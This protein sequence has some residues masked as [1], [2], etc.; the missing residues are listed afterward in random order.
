M[1]LASGKRGRYRYYKCNTQ[2]GKGSHLFQSKSIAMQKLD[3]IVLEALADKVFT[4]ERVKVMLTELKRRQ[5]AT[6]GDKE[7]ELRPLQKESS[8]A[9]SRKA[10]GYMRQWARVT[11]R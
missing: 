9:S 5:Q 10:R 3:G 11:C 4:P 6:L 1:T 2:I 8:A 7:S